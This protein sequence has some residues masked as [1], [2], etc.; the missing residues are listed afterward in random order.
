MTVDIS[1]ETLLETGAHFGHQTKR[2]NPK[3]APYVYGVKDGVY[4]IDLIKTKQELEKAF[5][6]LQ[7]ATKEDKVILFV[8]TKKN[9]REKIREI[10]EETGNPYVDERWLGGTLTNFEQIRNS[11]KTLDDLKEGMSSGEFNDR[12]KKERL[13]ID[14]KIEKLERFVGGLRKLEKAPDLMVVADVK[15]ERGAVFESKAAGVDLVGLVDT[16]SDPTEITYPIPVND[17]ATA[18]VVYVLDLIKQA[19]MEVKKTSKKAK[20]IKWQKL[21]QS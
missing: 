6:V 8:G 19:I 14:R 15:R 5:K 11:V 18:A 7:K 16:N 1:L 12:T 17:D 9:S 10:A 20:K 13:L 2:W 21:M 3:M 4:I